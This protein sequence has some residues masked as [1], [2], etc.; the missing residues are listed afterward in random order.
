MSN[1][2][3][4]RQQARVDQVASAYERLMREFVQWAQDEDNIRVAV[5][6]G[7]RARTDHPADE[8]S[9][10]DV[11]VFARDPEPSIREVR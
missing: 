1:S 10:L 11:L 4:L 5:I 8:W 9:G 6:M 7:S 3:Q 2:D